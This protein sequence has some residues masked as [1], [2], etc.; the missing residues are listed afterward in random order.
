MKIMKVGNKN[1]VAHFYFIV[2]YYC[3]SFLSYEQMMREAIALLHDNFILGLFNLTF[4]FGG[5]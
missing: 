2:G 4:N 1:I 3:Y 5:Q